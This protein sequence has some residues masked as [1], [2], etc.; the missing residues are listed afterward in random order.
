M[1]FQEG[2]VISYLT[3]SLAYR[4]SG[5]ISVEMTNEVAFPEMPLRRVTYILKVLLLL[6]AH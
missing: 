5:H 6:L 2:I 1:T 3:F 4:S